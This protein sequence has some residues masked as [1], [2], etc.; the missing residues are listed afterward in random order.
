MSQSFQFQIMWLNMDQIQLLLHQLIS[1][2]Q[3][4]NLLYEIALLTLVNKCGISVFSV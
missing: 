3:W 1:I 2:M 4:N